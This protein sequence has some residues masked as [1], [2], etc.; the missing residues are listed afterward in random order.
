MAVCYAKRDRFVVYN[1]HAS[2]HVMLSEGR[3][4]VSISNFLK[5]KN[6]CIWE[7]NCVSFLIMISALKFCIERAH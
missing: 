1:Y 7:T 5:E 2:L 6:I 3:H 4:F